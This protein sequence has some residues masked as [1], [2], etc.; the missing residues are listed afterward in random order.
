MA[1]ISAHFSREEFACQCG[2]GF[3]T[4]DAK[5]LEV[6]EVIR[7]HY[8]CPVKI[9]SGCRCE[10]H[11]KNIGG[12]D[13]SQHVQGRAADIQVACAHPHEVLDLLNKYY[14]DALGVGEYPRWIHIDSRDQK[15]RWSVV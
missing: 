2:C 11:N 3:D 12:A 10:Q 8:K 9:T 6:L 7:Q 14:P 1:K 4:V 5:L 13:K 15:S